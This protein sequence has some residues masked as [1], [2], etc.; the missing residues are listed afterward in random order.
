MLCY[1]YTLTFETTLE[2]TA[3]IFHFCS[4]EGSERCAKHRITIGC[5]WLPNKTL[6]D[7]QPPNS[8]R[9]LQHC[10]CQWKNEVGAD[11]EAL[12][13]I[14]AVIWRL[15]WQSK[16]CS[17]LPATFSADDW[18]IVIGITADTPFIKP[19]TGEQQSEKAAACNQARELEHTNY[20]CVRDSLS[21]TEGQKCDCLHQ[22][23]CCWFGNQPGC[24]VW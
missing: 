1:L 10:K 24:R 17:L 11:Q 9:F 2:K 8:I 3:K 23:L 7:P 4:P 22:Q 21:E 18:V 14:K 12:I 5:L 15:Q 6:L 20:F 13:N 19:L 16:H